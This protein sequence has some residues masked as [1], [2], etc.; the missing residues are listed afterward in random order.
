MTVASAAMREVVMKFL[1]IELLA[2]LPTIGFSLGELIFLADSLWPLWDREN[3]AL[4]DMLARTRVC[5]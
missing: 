1:A 4:H 3:R 5:Q 2:I